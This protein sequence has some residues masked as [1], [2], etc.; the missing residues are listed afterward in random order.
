M[1]KKLIILSVF[2]VCMLATSN[3]S[4]KYDALFDDASDADSVEAAAGDQAE[5]TLVERQEA[6]QFLKRLFH[7][8]ST[9]N[10][11]IKREVTEE[12]EE[13]CDSIVPGQR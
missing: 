8:F 10:E 12:Y 6:T 1:F 5:D 2:L 3:A 11:E 9:K 4:R 7:P 13:K